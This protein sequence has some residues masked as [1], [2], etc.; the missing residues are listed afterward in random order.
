M[1][2]SHENDKP[3]KGHRVRKEEENDKPHKHNTTSQQQQQKSILFLILFFS[4]WAKPKVQLQIM[5]VFRKR[6]LQS[7]STTKGNNSKKAITPEQN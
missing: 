4:P 3:K 2:L 6:V 1:P 5:K 7:D